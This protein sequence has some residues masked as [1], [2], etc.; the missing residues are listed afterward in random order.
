MNPFLDCPV[1]ET[2]HFIIKQLF[3]AAS[4]FISSQAHITSVSFGTFSYFRL[5]RVLRVSKTMLFPDISRIRSTAVVM[6]VCVCV[7]IHARS[8]IR[9]GRNKVPVMVISFFSMLLIVLIF[10]LFMVITLLFNKILSL[11]FL[12]LTL[13]IPFP[14]Q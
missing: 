10:V 14:S 3:Q 8:L 2:E 12:P 11:M 9:S 7:D 5:Y 4:Q 1:Y 13:Y 6:K